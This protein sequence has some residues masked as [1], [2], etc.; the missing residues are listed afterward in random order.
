MKLIQRLTIS[1][2]EL[3]LKKSEYIYIMKKVLFFALIITIFQSCKNTSEQKLPILGER[4]PVERTVDGK[5]LI[6]TIY[7]TKTVFW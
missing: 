1:A 5:V 2:F 3:A 7:Q 4:E 6:D